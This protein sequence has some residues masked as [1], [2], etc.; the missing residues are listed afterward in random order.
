MTWSSTTTGGPSTGPQ[1]A[2]PF[3][4]VSRMLPNGER[5]TGSSWQVAGL[6]ECPALNGVCS[7]P[8]SPSLHL[9]FNPWKWNVDAKDV[10]D[11]MKTLKYDDDVDLCKNVSTAPPIVVVVL[12]C[13]AL[14]HRRPGEQCHHKGHG[15]PDS[16]CHQP[17]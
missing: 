2:S 16:R 15:A 13:G 3:L 17:P 14:T 12:L 4:R 7:R 11:E 1:A 10:I 5:A 8:R 9:D 6:L